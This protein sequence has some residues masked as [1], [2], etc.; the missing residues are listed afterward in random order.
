[1]QPIEIG[2]VIYTDKVFDSAGCTRIICPVIPFWLLL[3]D[4]FCDRIKRSE[5]T[6]EGSG[7]G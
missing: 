2:S 5:G 7:E 4:V 1:V 3:D 6:G